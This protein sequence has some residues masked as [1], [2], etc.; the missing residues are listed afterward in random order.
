M[1][2]TDILNKIFG[3]EEPDGQRLQEVYLS[4]I[5]STGELRVSTPEKRARDQNYRHKDDVQFAVQMAVLYP[6]G[7][8][9]SDVGSFLSS[10]PRKRYDKV[11]AIYQNRTNKPFNVTPEAWARLNTRTSAADRAN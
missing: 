2:L 1:G 3:K 5:P 9:V 8:I 4:V 7:V 11:R 6:N 10:I